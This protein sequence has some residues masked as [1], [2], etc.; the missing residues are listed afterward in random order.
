LVVSQDTGGAIK[1]PVRGD[2]FW[3]TGNAA[4]DRAGMMNAH[5]WYYLLLPRSVV[6][7]LA[8][9]WLPRQGLGEQRTD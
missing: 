5:G 9:G 7:R 6:S 1:G 4:A 3:G 2:V 8:P